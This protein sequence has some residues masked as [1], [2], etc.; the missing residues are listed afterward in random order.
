[1][2]GI[3]DTRCRT[4]AVTHANVPLQDWNET[5]RE[6]QFL[7]ACDHTNIMAYHGCYLQVNSGFLL[8]TTWLFTIF[9]LALTGYLFHY[10]LLRGQAC[11]SL[12]RARLDAYGS[13]YLRFWDL[14]QFRR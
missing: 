2:F 10:L 9:G 11:H 6:I 12:G 5:R 14:Y 3:I 1:M 4:F 8:L 13:A 7:M